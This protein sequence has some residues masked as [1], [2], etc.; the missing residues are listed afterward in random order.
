M[1]EVR[2]GLPVLFVSGF[3][4]DRLAAAVE[5][6][7]SSAFLAKPYTTADLAG[8]VRRLLDEPPPV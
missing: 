2:S 3:A 4:T 6:T 5:A 8:T 7:S 1:R